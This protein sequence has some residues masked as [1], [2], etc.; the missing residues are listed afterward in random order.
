MKT[1]MFDI[2]KFQQQIR[3]SCSAAT[4]KLADLLNFILIKLSLKLIT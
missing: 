4:V 2:D 3:I 1:L